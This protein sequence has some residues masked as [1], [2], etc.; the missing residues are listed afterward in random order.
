MKILNWVQSRLNRRHGSKKQNPISAN[1]CQQEP[2]KE[3]FSDWPHGL[4]A[5]GTFGKNDVKEDPEKHNLQGSLPSSQDHLQDL[6]PEEVGKLQ[7]E[8]KSLLHK[9]VSAEHGSIPELDNPN[10]PLDKILDSLSSW[11]F[12]TATSNASTN[13]LKQRDDRLQRSSGLIISRGKD[14]C[15]DDSKSAIAKKSLSFLLKKM[16]IC[17]SGFAPTPSLKDPVPE[18]RMDKILRLLLHKKIYPQSSSS[19]LSIMRYLANRHMPKSDNE[20]EVNEKVTEGS[21]WVKTDSEYIVLEI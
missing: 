19:T 1:W 2:Q 5:I 9:Q 6:T 7:K 21:K 12:D 3:E 13:D 11:G 16:F 20:D 17:R 10:L 4:L 8:L 18:S 14:V 15:L